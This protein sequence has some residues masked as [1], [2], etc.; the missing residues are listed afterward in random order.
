MI[1]AHWITSNKLRERHLLISI[2]FSTDFEEGIYEL[3]RE[4][5]PMESWWSNH[6]LMHCEMISDLIDMEAHPDERQIIGKYD[7]FIAAKKVLV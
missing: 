5:A 7:Y 6:A 3:I 1:E 4:P 2:S